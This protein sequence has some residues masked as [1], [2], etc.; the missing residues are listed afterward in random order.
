MSTKFTCELAVQIGDINYGGHVGNEIYLLYFQEA[1]VRFLRELGL[2]ERNIGEGVS[3]T[4]T[5]AHINYKGEAFWG[6]HLTIELWID[7]I[8]KV[9]FCVNYRITNN[10][11]GRLVADGYT[12]LAGFDYQIHKPRRL[13]DSFVKKLVGYRAVSDAVSEKTDVE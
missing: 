13:P 5:E 12:T 8:S 3:L 10:K 1:R 11:S 2:S 9:R 7:D 4:Q 6:D